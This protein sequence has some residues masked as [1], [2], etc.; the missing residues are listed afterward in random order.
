M[1]INEH[2][3]LERY[4]PTPEELFEVNL[5]EESFYYKTKEIYVGQGANKN[6]TLYCKTES[7]RLLVVIGESWTYGDNLKPY[8]RCVEN[9][10]NIPYRVSTIFAGKVATYLKSDLLINSQP[11]NCNINHYYRLS[12]YIDAI[13]E[14]GSYDEVFLVFQLTSPGRDYR[15]NMVDE[16]IKHLFSKTPNNFP[17]LEYHDWQYEYDKTYFNL[18]QEQVLRM[19]FKST[20]IW[21]NFNEFHYKERDQYNFDVIEYP[22]M[23][24]VIQMSGYDYEPSKNMEHTFYENINELYNLK[25]DI[26]TMEEEIDKQ[27]KGLQLLGKS[28]LNNFHP[29]EIGHWFLTAL[30]IDKIKSNGY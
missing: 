1:N 23:R 16:P 24:L 18:I 30:I 8:V 25:V 12:E 10:D 22:F 21:K 19:Q 15:N 2:L 17:I 14:D 27:N 20:V 9:K 28:M 13:Q 29:N 7:K 3:N 26:E 4:E 6:V 5:H 11:G